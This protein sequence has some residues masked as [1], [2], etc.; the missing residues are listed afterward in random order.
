M[1]TGKAE[2]WY[3]SM[4][5]AVKLKIKFGLRHD[6]T[7]DQISAW[8]RDVTDRLQGG[9]DPEEAA[10]DAAFA[11]FEGVDKCSYASEADNIQALLKALAAKS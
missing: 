5:V 7:D 1:A 3:K 10:R 4:N 11:H 2:D 6:P 9:E 8:L